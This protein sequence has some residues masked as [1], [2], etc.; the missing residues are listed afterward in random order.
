MIIT[1]NETKLVIQN[2]LKTN[3]GFIYCAVVEGEL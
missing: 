3:P 2:E 1:Q